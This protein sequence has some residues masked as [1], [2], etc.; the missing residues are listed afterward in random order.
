MTTGGIGGM[1]GAAVGFAVGAAVGAAVGLAVGTA[2]GLAVGATGGGVGGADVGFGVD[3]TVGIAVGA[4]VG[5][6]V[7]CGSISSAAAPEHSFSETELPITLN[8]TSSN[9]PNMSPMF[10]FCKGA[11]LLHATLNC[12]VEI[13]LFP[14]DF[15]TIPTVPFVG[16]IGIVN[17]SPTCTVDCALFTVVRKGDHVMTWSAVSTTDVFNLYLVP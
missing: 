13:F 16:L 9:G 12:V 4:A 15:N 1:V 14:A 17:V 2:V 8:P 6:A 5:A 10:N 3:A 7:G 11:A